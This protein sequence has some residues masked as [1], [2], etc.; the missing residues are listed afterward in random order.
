VRPDNNIPNNKPDNVILYN[1]KGRYMIKDVAVPGDRNVI[2]KEVEKILKHKDLIIEIHR[3]WSMQAKVIPVITGATG[4]I[5]K[6]L[7]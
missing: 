5:S 2:K 7:T 1:K 3:M 4:N 6:S